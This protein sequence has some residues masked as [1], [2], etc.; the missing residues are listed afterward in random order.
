M[1]AWIA[2]TGPVESYNV[3]VDGVIDHTVIGPVT[4]KVCIY[5]EDTHII[6]VVP[7]DAEGKE[8]ES[9]DALTLTFE[10][11]KGGL[12]RE[13]LHPTAHADID[14]DGVI[15][16]KD[17]GLFTQQWGKCHNGREEIQCP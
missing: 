10:I 14:G 12:K 16:F 17:F 8:W 6:R 2:S 13:P 1:I 9:S 11:N 4:D 5:D 7:V 3:Y 15:G